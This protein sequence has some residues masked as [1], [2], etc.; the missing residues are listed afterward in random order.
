LADSDSSGTN[1]GVGDLGNL[2]GFST[3]LW[4]WSSSQSDGINA[5]GQSLGYANQFVG[6]KFNALRVRA[7]RSF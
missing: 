1:S 4:Y 7:V 2:G 6:E 5:W 3:G